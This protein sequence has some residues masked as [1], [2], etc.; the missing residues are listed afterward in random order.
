MHGEVKILIVKRKLLYLQLFSYI[1]GSG[2]EGRTTRVQHNGGEV[3][4]APCEKYQ[5]GEVQNKLFKKN[6]SIEI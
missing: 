3:T 5:M 1:S 4:Q 2:A 6:G